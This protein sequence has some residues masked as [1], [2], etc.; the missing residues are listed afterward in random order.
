MVV[1][2]AAGNRLTH[3]YNE[4]PLHS[5]GA[6]VHVRAPTHLVGAGDDFWGWGKE[7]APRLLSLSKG[8]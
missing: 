8:K 7:S 2:P 1:T 3:D 5:Q 4:G 6:F